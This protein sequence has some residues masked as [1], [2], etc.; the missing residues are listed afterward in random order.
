[1]VCGD[2]PPLAGLLDSRL[3]GVRRGVNGVAQPWVWRCWRSPRTRTRVGDTLLMRR[4]R[5][6]FRVPAAL[7]KHNARSEARR[8]AARL[9]F[10]GSVHHRVRNFVV[11]ELPRAQ[12]PLS[13]EAIAAGVGLETGRVR[14]ILDELE[15]HLTF[16]G[17][18][19]NQEQ[20]RGR[21][22]RRIP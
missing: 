2:P 5:R 12:Q 8:A 18:G 19:R 11:A 10:M 14:E 15:A 3:R 16:L 21:V 1:V 20:R 4:K 7:W 9:E 22:E 13:P 6:M 17:R